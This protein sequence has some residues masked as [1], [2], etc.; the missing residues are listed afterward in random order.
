MKDADDIISWCCTFEKNT[1]IAWIVNHT[2]PDSERMD[3][4]YVLV[5]EI[6]EVKYLFLSFVKITFT[7]VI[8]NF[9]LSIVFE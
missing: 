4:T 6:P 5:K 3:C 9:Q 8:C 2:N 1:N 7:D